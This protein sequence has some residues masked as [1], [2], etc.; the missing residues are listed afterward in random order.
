[1]EEVSLLERKPED[2]NF[3]QF[4]SIIHLAAIVHQTK[5]IS[6]NV[7]FEINR[8]L[9]LKVAENAKK[10]GVKQ[11]VFLS[12]V[13]VYGDNQGSPKPIN[14]DSPCI[15]D[16]S[17]GKSKLEAELGLRKLED[18]NFTVSVIRTPLV[19][20]A[21]VKANMLSIMKLCERLPILPFGKVDNK[22]S[23]TFVENLVAYIDCIIEKRV[24]GLFIAKD[25][26][27]ISTSELVKLISKYLRKK[28]I[29]IKVP[30]IFLKIGNLFF[31]QILSRLYGSL[32]FDNS[33]TLEL[34]DFNPPYST[35]EGIERMVDS[36]IAQKAND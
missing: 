26:D 2:I 25:K 20:G 17:Y 22:R 23:F 1:M 9:C 35:E 36:Y 6:E 12:T 3:N 33:K 34:L 19:Y 27:S 24:S 14:E 10:A 11:F 4:T 28:V 8:D 31:P 30:E 16:D 5:K 18:E 7:Y 15:P 32:E 29:L 13:K 21:G